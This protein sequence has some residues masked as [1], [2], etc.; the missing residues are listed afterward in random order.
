MDT[1]F[2]KEKLSSLIDSVYRVTGITISVYDKNFNGICSVSASMCSFCEKVRG[3]DELKKRCFECDRKALQK[4]REVKLRYEYRCH[5]G[6]ME[7]ATPIIYNNEILGF[8]LFGQLTDTDDKSSIKY[9]AVKAAKELSLPNDEFL[10]EIS[11]V[12]TLA[13]DYI[14]SVSDIVKM[15]AEYIV[16][17]KMLSYK[18]SIEKQIEAYVSSRITSGVSVD[19]ICKKFGICA[20][21]LYNLSIKCFGCGIKEYI[22][23]CKIKL[24]K[25]M[26]ESDKSLAQVAES[27][28]FCDVNYFIRF[29]KSKTGMT[30]KSYKMRVL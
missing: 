16:M 23:K 9:K 19:D 29:F 11:S 18:E 10:K 22:N 24:A 2:D 21:T 14:S 12:R 26:L 20:T 8:I 13:H 1:Y 27:L 28:G 6:L 3:K 7:V 4:C 17:N 30:P 15:A 5:M 25:E